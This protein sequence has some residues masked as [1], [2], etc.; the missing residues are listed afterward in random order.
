MRKF[1]LISIVTLFAFQSFTQLFGQSKK[2]I[3]VKHVPDNAISALNTKYGA[4]VI[5]KWDRQG[6]DYYATFEIDKINYEAEFSSEGGWLQTEKQ[7]TEA[8]LP[9]SVNDA[10]FNG[11]YQDWT[12]ADFVFIE[13]TTG[14]NMYRASIIKGDKKRSLLITPDGKVTDSDRL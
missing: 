14:E 1:F 5:A 4:D 10:L 6:S 11:D 8:D 7:V 9:N 12:K 2:D 13:K 3:K